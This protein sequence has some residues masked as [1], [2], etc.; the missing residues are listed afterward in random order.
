M[1]NSHKAKHIGGLG[2]KNSTLMNVAFMAKL[3]WDLEMQSYK[4]WAIFLKQKYKKRKK[5]DA[6]DP[7][8]NTSYIFRGI[9]KDQNIFKNCI[10]HIIK[11]GETTNL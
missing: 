3:I 6:S 4:L 8:K 2:I 9:Y 7:K 11:I 10:N 1:G 5:K